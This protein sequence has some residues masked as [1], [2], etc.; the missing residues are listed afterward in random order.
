MTNAVNL[1]ALGSNGSA[2]LPNWTTGTRPSS[3][4]TGQSGFNT[5]NSNLEVYNGSAWVA[6]GSAITQS[7]QA[8]GFSATAG[9]IY[10]CNTTSAAFTVTLPASP[11]VGD[12]ISVFD[13]AGTFATNNLTV[14][15]NGKNING[16]SSSAIL[17]TNRESVTIVY[18]DATQ[19][20]AALSTGSVGT[21]PL[22]QPYSAS[23][24]LVAGGGGGGYNYA[25]G[26]GAGGMVTGTTSLIPGSSYTITIG[27]GGPGATTGPSFSNNGSDSSFPGVTTAVGGGGGGSGGTPGTPGALGAGKSG[28][29]GGGTSA[30]GNAPYAGGAATPGQGN[31]GGSC[32]TAPSETAG[33]GGGAGAAGGNAN[34]A[35]SPRTTGGG[36]AGLT[37][38]ISGS[39]VYYAGGGGGG[40]YSPQNSTA[41]TGTPSTGGGAAGVNNPG[42]TGGTGTANTG[43]GGGGGGGA[44]GSGGAGGSGIFILSVPTS[45][46][47]GTKTGT[48]TTATNGSN[49]VITWTGSGTYTA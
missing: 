39:P 22:P 4:R 48:S 16:S 40:G 1:S 28:G 13:Y 6:V 5:T 12:Q 45:K 37:T 38:S 21:S 19:G 44:F 20:W 30:Q 24:V 35:T 27:G 3:P 42:G 41:G 23:Y 32:G 15:P 26:G 8:T 14:N 36:G 46:Y 2:S 11:N 17:S 10:P 29:S 31:S 34:P 47:P 7:V 43:G 49:T 9:N 18:V 33:G 25:G